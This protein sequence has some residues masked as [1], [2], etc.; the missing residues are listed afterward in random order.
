MLERTARYLIWSLGTSLLGAAVCIILKPHGLAA[1]AGLSYFGNFKL[2]IIPYGVALLGGSYFLHQAASSLPAKGYELTKAALTF[3]SILYVILF[4]TPYTLNNIVDWTHTITGVILFSCELI[5]TS[6]FVFKS[7]F[8]RFLSVA[9]VC[10]IASGI[11]CAI[12]TPVPR[13][14]LLQCQIVFQIAFT[15]IYV[16]YL[17]LGMNVHKA[18]EKNIALPFKPAA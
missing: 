6:W 3:F 10:Q 11:L 2:T 5:L 7:S 18:S 12:Y 14:Y 15:T 9:W 8:N 1:N 13:G 17:S 4:I 16:K